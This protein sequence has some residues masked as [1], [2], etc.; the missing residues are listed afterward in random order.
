MHCVISQTCA[1]LKLIFRP[2]IKKFSDFYENRRFFLSYKIF[3][4]DQ[5][6]CHI[7][8]VIIFTTP[9]MA[10]WVTETWRWL[11]RQIR[12]VHASNSF[13]LISIWILSLYLRLVLASVYFFRFNRQNSIN[14]FLS[15]LYHMPCPSRLPVYDPNKTSQ[16]IKIMK[17]LFAEFPPTPA[18]FILPKPISIPQLLVQANT[19][20]VFFP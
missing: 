8:I 12:P 13:S 14:F 4:K 19:Q 6:I 15:D 2:T 7:V 17:F 5:Q 3:K 1:D 16:R 20:P 18:Y 10:T 9:K 11:Q